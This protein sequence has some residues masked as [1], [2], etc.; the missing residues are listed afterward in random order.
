MPDPHVADRAGV[1]R[2]GGLHRAVGIY[3]VGL[4]GDAALFDC[5]V[6][7]DLAGAAAVLAHI[8]IDLRVAAAD[9]FP[10]GDL[11][12]VDVDK[13]FKGELAHLVGGIH[14]DRHPV[15]REGETLKTVLLDLV[16]FQRAAGVAD[17][18][19]PLAGLLDADARAAAGHS[20]ADIGIRAHDALGR[21]FHD[22]NMRGA[23]RDIDLALLPLENVQR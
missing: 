4:R 12:G 8:E 22:R 6:G 3:D 7:E 14:D 16:F 20:D 10:V 11:A 18:H 5:L 1:L 19:E 23:A 13:L 15:D 2:H 17:L 21:L 9:L